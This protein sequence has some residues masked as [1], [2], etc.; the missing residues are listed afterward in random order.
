VSRNDAVD[1]S[2]RL[3]SRLP[4]NYRAYDAEPPQDY[5]MLALLRVIGEQAANLRLDLDDLW[6]DFFIETASDWVVPY[7]GALLG[8]RLLA[9]PVEQG[10]RLEVA[11]TVR[12][13]RTR[14]TPAM[15]RS[16]ARS[17]TG[18]PDDLAEY[19]QHLG[20][21]QNV[22]HPRR[23]DPLSPDLRDTHV[24]SRLGRADDSASH[25]A[26]F[27]LSAAL[28]AAR[29]DRTSLGIGRAAWGTPG[30][31]DIKNLGFLVRR[32]LTFRLEGVTPAADDP[33]LPAP[34]DPTCFTFDPLHHEAPLFVEATREPLT[35]SEFDQAPWATFGSDVA[36]R[37]VGVLLASDAEPAAATSRSEVPFSFGG[38][39]AGLRLDA[40]DGLRLLDVRPFDQGE[41]HF[42]I[43]AFW[44][45]DAGGVVRLGSLSTLLAATGGGAAYGAHDTATGPGRLVLRV[46]TGRPIVASSNPPVIVPASSAGGRFPGAVVAAQAILDGRPRSADALYVYLPPS[47]LRPADAP[48]D[49]PFQA[50]GR[51][52]FHVAVDGTT[53]SQIDMKAETLARPS[54]GQIYPPRLTTASTVPANGFVR[55]ARRSGRLSAAERIDSRP[56]GAYLLDDGRFG[57]ARAI[58]RLE[59]F[60]GTFQRLGAIATIERDQSAHPDLEFS[61]GGPRWPSF[62]Y[63]A[64]RFA[65]G[66]EP[67]AGLLA[68]HVAVVDGGD[69]VPEA[70]LVIVNRAG[71][72]LLVYLPEL[73]GIDADGVRMFIGAD[74]SSH[75]APAGDD[76]LAA[77]QAARS[78]AG[79]PTARPSAGQVLPIAGRRPLQQRR[80]MAIELCSGRCRTRL[81]PGELGIDPERGTFA[82]AAGDP[83]IGGGRLSVD[84]VE[85]F[86][87]RIGAR[88]YT[89]DLDGSV[90]TRIVAQLGDAPLI[91]RERVHTTFEDAFIHSGENGATEE[92]IEI[93]DSA[94][95]ILD[96]EL[97]FD[98]LAGGRLT[99]RAANG[100]RPCIVLRG[101][102]PASP[103]TSPL[104]SP[105]TSPPSSP[106]TPPGGPIL[107]FSS[108]LE[109]LELG[110]LLISGGAVHIATPIK[111]ALISACTLDPRTAAAASLIVTDE[112]RNSQ[113]AYLIC[114]SVSGGLTI[115]DGVEQVTIADTIIDRFGGLAIGGLTVGAPPASP[116]SSPPA[117]PPSSP[118]ASPPDTARDARAF[119]RS[120]GPSVGL[121]RGGEMVRIAT[122]V[123]AGDVGLTES[124]IRRLHLERV[125]VL[126]RIRCEVLEASEC[127]LDD[128]TRVEDQ[129]AGCIRFSRYEIGSA[130]PRRYQCVP[131]DEQS[132]AWTSP[133]RCE[134]PLF[135]SR[136]YGWPNYVQLAARTPDSVRNASER[137]SEVGAF[138]GRLDTLRRRNFEIKTR[139]FL[140]VGLSALALAE[141]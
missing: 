121:T 55:I 102:L 136:T 50:T 73:D 17:V 39:G 61:M 120:T 122:R 7:L 40:L 8:T 58:Y 117:G 92:V 47:F 84:Y 129:Q 13:R 91:A 64:R 96:Q 132:G 45:E 78:L 104:S 23:S 12:W 90:P 100:V 62:S 75:F 125:T 32:L 38:R 131:S 128:I 34:V 119:L 4:A 94:T 18:W 72:S 63:A 10:D 14:G 15:L 37:Q 74:G 113:S 141:T 48:V 26:D 103:P 114:R 93:A 57:S 3:Y 97:V 51:G 106:P 124:P 66:D 20:W 44:L 98:R 116:P 56:S 138:T 123:M 109:R 80:P 69:W 31:Y 41:P 88:T 24:L 99:I 27:R 43:E 28:D 25:A 65:P 52:V 33:R 108:P 140:P 35:R 5:A 115:G 49:V 67:E 60:T 16:L 71:D 139:E 89:R 107:K 59:L 127:L 2:Q 110:G 134:A 111:A 81:L 101:S 79:L 1:L 82:F 22:N 86:S 135:G 133:A 76:A 6:D 118:P 112:D 85:A 29:L 54:D 87:D 95:Y 83:A 42:V 9:D 126:G 130:L 53:Y 105:P 36:I 11:N 19:F 77:I 46:V 137:R 21:S 30:R 68:V 70:E